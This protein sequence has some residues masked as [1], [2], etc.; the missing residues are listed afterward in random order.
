MLVDKELSS[1][2]KASSLAELF[3]YTGRPAFA[4]KESFY[5]G[6]AAYPG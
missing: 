6:T 3:S 1:S 2:G 4:N 5:S